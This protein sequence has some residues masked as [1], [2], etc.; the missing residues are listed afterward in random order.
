MSSIHSPKRR[1]ASFKPPI[2]LRALRALVCASVLSFVTPALGATTGGWTNAAGNVSRADAAGIVATISGSLGGSC[3]GTSAGYGADRLNNTSNAAGWFS[4]PYGAP[5]SGLRDLLLDVCFG[6][7]SARTITMTFSK[8]VD[9]PVLHVDRLGGWRQPA[10]NPNIYADSSWWKLAGSTSTGG[11]VALRQLS[12]NPQ[13]YVGPAEFVRSVVY[14]DGSP[15]YV[16]TASECGTKIAQGTACGSIEFQ[17]TGITRL[18]FSVTGTAWGDVLGNDDGDELELA[19]SVQG[20]RITLRKQ[21]IGGYGAFGF[22][23]DNTTTA[24]VGTLAT[25]SSTTLTTLASSN[26]VASGVYRVGDHGRDIVLAETPASGFVLQSAACQDQN[27][28]AVPATLSGSALTIAAANYRANQDIVC[29][30]GNAQTGRITLTKAWVAG[31]PGDKVDLAID[32]GS[33]AIAGTSTPEATTAATAIGT[34]GSTI[35]I[36]ETF[37]TAARGDD[38]V[39]SL[40]CPGVVVGGATADRRAGTFEMPGA[41]VTCTFTNARRPSLK[42]TK[43]SNANPAWVVGQNG[44]QYT[45]N[46]A[47]QG[48]VA[49]SGTVTV[50]D[51]LPSQVSANWTDPLT[52]DD[53]TCTRS[54]QDVSCRTS[55]S[56]AASGTA[57]P[58][59]LPVNVTGTGDVTNVAAAGGGGDPY[60][61]GSAPAPGAG[62]TDATH[63]ASNTAHV[64]ASADIVVSKSV[65]DATPNVGDTVTFTIAAKNAGPS[66]ATGVAIT[67][68]LP[69]GLAF[70][71]ATP[72]QGN[73]DET[74]ERWTVGA[75]ANGAQ[76]SLTLAAQVLSAGALANTATKTAGD[77]FDPDTSNNAAS[78]SIN[79]QASADLQVRKEASTLTPNLGSE[80]SFTITVRNAGPSDATGVVIDDQLPAGLNF[81]S[82]TASV[83]NYDEDAG[84]W[85]LGALAN[86]AEATLSVVASVGMPG[87]LTNTAVVATS[88]QH[89]PNPANDSAGVTINGQAADIQI[90]KTVDNTNPI[91][92]STVTFTVTA[93][94]N[95]PSAAGGVRVVDALPA[96]LTFVSATAEQGTYDSAN[97]LWTIG[98]LA[99]SG[100]AATATLTLV[101]TVDTD[102]AVT[103]TARLDGVDQTDPDPSNNQGQAALAPIA[104]ADLSVAKHGPVDATPGTNVSYRIVVSN[105]GPSTAAQASLADPTP[106]GLTFVAADAPC[107][108]GFPCALGDIAV[109]ARVSVNVTYAVASDYAGTDPIANTATV[110]SA[111]DDPDA[112]NDRSTATTPLLRSADV[113]VTKTGPATVAAGASITYEIQV[114][115]A[116]PSD[117][118]GTTLS[119]PLPAGLSDVAVSCGD[120]SGGAVCGAFDERIAGTLARLPASGRVTL[121]VTATAPN[122]AATLVNTASVAPPDGVTDPDPDNARSSVTTEV[123]AP[124]PLAAPSVTKSVEAIDAQTLQWTIVLINDRNASA[125]PI[126]LRD[127]LPAGMSFVA[128]QIACTARG[129]SA[130]NDCRYGDAD[131]R[132]VAD[133]RLE[134][135]PGITDPAA[136]QNAVV[137]TF[138]TRYAA[139]P[140]PV[141]NTAEAYWDANHDGAVGDDIAAGQ[142]PVR[143]SATYTPAIPPGADLE[144]RKTGPAVAAPGQNVVYTIAVTNHGPDAVADAELDDPTPPGLSYVAASAPCAN[145]FPCALGALAS[146]ATTTVTVTY[147]VQPGY[148]GAVVNRATTHSPTVRDPNPDNNA[149]TVTTTIAGMPPAE[150]KP[151]PIDAR[152]MLTLMAMSLLLVGVFAGARRRR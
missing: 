130:V 98:D 102:D 82:A 23:D 53:W 22:S 5:V 49:T 47:N 94:N 112:S 122:A 132:I 30:F 79:A 145:G 28:A 90:L 38:Y 71:G 3:L 73:Y 77:Q 150:I 116:G 59:V 37:A 107:A 86:G 85:T 70:V 34:A 128:G 149:D 126:A 6:D 60:N 64:D 113:Q 56:I 103:N 104:S 11:S 137:V 89:D 99:A 39:T 119:D 106:A 62:C 136:A 142:T 92:G 148:E 46:V 74:S 135:D 143:A 84:T 131:A 15:I 31:V 109:G 1:R 81:V 25:A 45:L 50:L 108:S 111:T 146:G 57:Q 134:P 124:T 78:A 72:S 54:G 95:G 68:A 100:D 121:T 19:W 29:T 2:P 96:G 140:A 125:L 21:T 93:T 58:I 75:L 44:A 7:N 88:D 18:T 115:N 52:T 133:A 105:A 8:P 20:S 152:W 4:N 26:P 51:A 12:G 127:P 27:G 129:A 33:D 76:A 63:C 147:T 118:D 83:G 114:S 120:E 40:E 13:M 16:D 67:D 123:Q 139:A 61:G 48:G 66:D 24:D 151:V 17:G 32:G 43:G 42:L 55:A 97:G 35:S 65:D 10:G 138:Q 69:A 36:E 41:D 80:V 110:S 141:T 91:R 101:A 87:E 117:A 14:A 144:T 9:N